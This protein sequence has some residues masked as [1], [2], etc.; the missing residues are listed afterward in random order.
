MKIFLE[1]FHRFL[2]YLLVLLLPV[3]LGKYFW[4]DWSFVNGIRIDYLAPTIYLTDI[5]VVGILICWGIS[6]ALKLKIKNQKLK[7]PARRQARHIKNQKAKEFWKTLFYSFITHYSLLITIFF[8]LN[9]FFAQNRQVVIFKAL[10]I[11]ELVLLA[12]YVKNNIAIKQSKRKSFALLKTFTSEEP[13]LTS[14]EVKAQ[15]FNS[16]LTSLFSI[17]VIYTSLIA[18]VQFI[19]Q[20]SIGGLFWWL[21]E[22]TFVSSTPGIAQVILNG[23]LVLRPYGTFSHPNV[24]GGYIATVLPL[25]M[26]NKKQKTKNK[27]HILKIKKFLRTIAI[28]LGMTTLFITYS[29]AAWVIG[30]MG[31]VAAL[32]KKPKWLYGCMAI[33]F[34]VLLLLGGQRLGQL[35][36][37]SESVQLRQQLNQTALTMIK[38]YPLFGVGLNNFIPSLPEFKKGLSFK[39][40]QPVHN[41][42]L[43][44]GAEMGLVG[45]GALLWL[46]VKAYQK[47]ISNCSNYS[48]YSKQ[49]PNPKHQTSKKSLIEVLNIRNCLGQLEIRSIR[50]LAKANTM[51]LFISLACIL[52]LGLVDHYFFTLQQTQLLLAIVL[53]MVFGYD[54][55]E[56]GSI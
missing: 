20:A 23:R 37:N 43:L 15:N 7:T 12:F 35:K 11:I 17:T 46:I 30:G 27:K 51:P 24:L 34:I 22:R 25:I 19:N 36:F 31:I 55:I 56:Q 48:N 42:Y 1:K 39:E 10:K 33:W 29:R 53:G 14:E 52:L 5:L 16:H 32:K 26:I 3:Q 8:L 41:I 49:A 40:L 18:W 47:L 54:G 28:C 50:N 4:P 38:K 2:F 21:G 13:R 9:I 44:I 6:A 45:L